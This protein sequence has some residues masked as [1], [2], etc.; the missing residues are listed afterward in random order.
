[1]RADTLVWPPPEERIQAQR[2]KNTAFGL[3]EDPAFYV[4]EGDLAVIVRPAPDSP[5]RC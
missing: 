4:D 1:M 3:F 5:A 2:T